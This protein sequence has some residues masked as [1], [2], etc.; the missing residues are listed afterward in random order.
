MDN[1]VTSLLS[2]NGL[3]TFHKYNQKMMVI[4][5]KLQNEYELMS[6]APTD[7]FLRAK[8]S[9]EY[10][11][12]LLEEHDAVLQRRI[13]VIKAES[14]RQRVEKENNLRVAEENF[15][16]QK[17]KK[18]R[19]ILRVEQELRDIIV[20]MKNEIQLPDSYYQRF[21]Q[22]ALTPTAQ[23]QM[24]S[25]PQ[26]PITQDIETTTNIQSERQ[27]L[28]DELYSYNKDAEVGPWMDFDDLRAA[29]RSAKRGG[30]LQNIW[31]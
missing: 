5:H 22:F 18:P 25:L 2:E 23:N 31:N 17:Q 1:D 9:V 4:Y 15:E 29:I 14:N 26:P 20:K 30:N 24:V 21:Q 10:H 12:K 8:K 27:K 7:L 19:S 3:K 28:I 16:I 6:Q 13:E 11:K